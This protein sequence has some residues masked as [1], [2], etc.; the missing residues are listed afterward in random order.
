MRLLGL[1][2]FSLVLAGCA[3]LTPSEKDRIRAAKNICNVVNVDGTTVKVT[4]GAKIDGKQL[5]PQIAEMKVGTPGEA[6]AFQTLWYQDLCM[7]SYVAQQDLDRDAWV[8][9]TGEAFAA[10]PVFDTATYDAQLTTLYAKRDKHLQRLQEKTPKKLGELM[11]FEVFDAAIP[12]QNFLRIKEV[13]LDVKLAG[14]AVFQGVDLGGST[15]QVVVSAD[16]F[17]HVI[18]PALNGIREAIARFALSG[19]SDMQMVQAAVRSVYDAGA[20]R[21]QQGKEAQARK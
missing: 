14:Q 16:Q 5:P 12:R 10:W 7:V 20:L 1:L 13:S 6:V 21:L 15:G 3:T 11:R 9:E 4:V 18:R 17:S 8:T 2:L 19:A